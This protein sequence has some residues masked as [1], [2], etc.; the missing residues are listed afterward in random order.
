MGYIRKHKADL[1]SGF[2]AIL[3]IG[4]TLMLSPILIV[5]HASTF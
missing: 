5:V 2:E 4:I 1:R 3:I